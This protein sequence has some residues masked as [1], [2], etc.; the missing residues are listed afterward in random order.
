MEVLELGQVTVE[1]LVEAEGPGFHPSFLL[2]D[3]DPELIAAQSAWLLPHFLDPM[4]GRFIQ[5]VQTYVVR[6]P[7][8]T[9]LVDTCVGNHKERP[10]TKA[11]HRMETRWLENLVAMGVAPEA[12]DYV[13]CTHL[14]VD[15]VGWNTRLENGRWVPTF[16]N[17]K[18]LFHKDEYAY[19][20]KEGDMDAGVGAGRTEGCFADSVLPVME[21]G[22]ALLVDDGYQIDDTMSLIHTPGHSPGHVCLRLEAGGGRAI[23]SGDVLHH[24]VQ[25]AH[26]EW[27]SRYCWDAARSRAARRAFVEENADTETLILAAHFATPTVGRIVANGAR[28]KFQI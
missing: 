25:C 1:R 12:V 17:A 3:S 15:H 4:S 11:W 9:I 23:F 8:H 22:Q 21:A 10:S 2:P 18:Y 19:W 13:L 14:H 6:T 16:A 7:R 5:C 20:E 27:N 26:P 28:A 24:P